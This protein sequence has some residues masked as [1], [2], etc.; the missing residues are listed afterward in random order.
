MDDEDLIRARRAW[1]SPS[2]LGLHQANN[3]ADR[4]PPTAGAAGKGLSVRWPPKKRHVVTTFSVRQ[5]PYPAAG[6]SQQTA[7]LNPAESA[8]SF[9]TRGS[10]SR[11]R[12]GHR[13]HFLPIVPGISIAANHACRPGRR[14]SGTICRWSLPTVQ[15]HWCPANKLSGLHNVNRPAKIAMK[16]P[17]DQADKPLINAPHRVNDD[18]VNA[19]HELL[20][21]PS[22]STATTC[23]CSTR[24]GSVGVRGFVLNGERQGRLHVD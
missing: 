13:Q 16:S 10:R 24:V 6:F 15:G 20:A 14:P 4:L 18:D 12:Q 23:G 11:Q 19:G 1:S 21:V 8:G 7:W 5:H 3:G 2:P 9:A 17:D 22:A